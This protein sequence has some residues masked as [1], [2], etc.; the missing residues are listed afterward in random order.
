MDMWI[1]TFLFQLSMNFFCLYIIVQFVYLCNKIIEGSGGD[2]SLVVI[3]FMYGINY[4]LI[5]STTTTIG[6]YSVCC[7]FTLCFF[8]KNI[9]VFDAY[10]FPP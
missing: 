9:F 8:H 1:S 6:R 4:N 5:M 3:N 10:V 2:E 7:Q